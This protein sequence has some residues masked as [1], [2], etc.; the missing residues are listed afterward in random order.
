[1]NRLL[2]VRFGMTKVI[3]V[4][5]GCDDLARDQAVFT[6]SSDRSVM[7]TFE[8]ELAVLDELT[9]DV[10]SRK[11]VKIV[12]YRLLS[13]F[14]SR[15][16]REARGQDLRWFRVADRKLTGALYIA[17][18][19]MPGCGHEAEVILPSHRRN[20]VLGRKI[21]RSVVITGANQ[22]QRRDREKLVPD[23]DGSVEF[24][25]VFWR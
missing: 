4:R 14:T 23:R 7:T 18:S 2:I 5:I 1:M 21:D 3:V 11:C 8:E 20:H 12:E 16:C 9:I 17:A 6:E 24:D 22:N 10:P 13:G 15:R 19:V 25:D